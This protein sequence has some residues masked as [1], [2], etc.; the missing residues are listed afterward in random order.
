M[1]PVL[2]VWE[3]QEKLWG[4]SEMCENHKVREMDIKEELKEQ[5]TTLDILDNIG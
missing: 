2:W 4:K 5:Q 1:Q 3:E